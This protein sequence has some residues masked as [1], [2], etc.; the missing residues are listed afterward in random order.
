M[1]ISAFI[2]ENM[3]AILQ[4]WEQFANTIQPKTGDMNEED[5]RDHAKLMLEDIADHLDQPEGLHEQAEKPKGR[6]QKSGTTSAAE[7]H[8]LARLSSGFGITGVVSEYRALRASV[9]RLWSEQR[10]QY[11][12]ET[13]DLILFN[14]ILDR[15]INE[16]VGSFSAEKERQTRLYETVLS[17][18][19]DHEYILDMDGRFLYANKPMLLVFNSSLGKRDHAATPTA[20]CI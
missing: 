7:E 20:R 14:E 9:I 5:L 18:S 17:S 2:R 11:P 15:E 10:P 16:A 1:K 13:I 12:I 3:G 6:N 4:E 8:G 19:S